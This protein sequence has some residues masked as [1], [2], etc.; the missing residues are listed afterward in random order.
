MLEENGHS[1]ESVLKRL[2]ELLLQDSTYQSGHPIASMSTIPDPLGV[3][4]FSRTLEKN[5]GRLHTFQGSAHVEEE[6]IEM[7]SDLLHLN[8]PLGTTSSGGTESNILAMLAARERNKEIEQPEVIVPRTAHSSIDK[9]AWLLGIKLVKTDIDEC[10]RAI[11]EAIEEAITKKTICIVGTAGTTYLGQIDP[12]QEIGKIAAN[13]D[14]LFHVDAAFGGFVIP[15]LND[16]TKSNHMFDFKVEGVTSIST[17]PHKMGL[18]PIP[19]GCIL[20]RRRDDFQGIIRSVPY[21][22]GASSIQAT[23]LGTRP[24]ASILATWVIMKHYGRQGYRKI[25]N[26]CMKRTAIALNRIKQN[27]KIKSAIEPIMNIIGIASEDIPLQTIVCEME[28]RGWRLATSPLPSTIRMVIMP[29]V[30]ESAIQS[31]FDDID[32]II[33]RV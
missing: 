14:I 12:I 11:P 21:L 24:A 22:Q 29:H 10:Y 16:L 30:T 4:V 2:D 15:F 13:N 20:F 3:E 32:E 17:D 27:P 23:I 28:K 1:R 18:A 8:E 5:A 25:V 19:A 7:I 33:E 9:A 31:F 6:V 26:Q